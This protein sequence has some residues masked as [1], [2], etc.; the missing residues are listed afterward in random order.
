MTKQTRASKKRATAKKKADVIV[1]ETIAKVKASP[2]SWASERQEG[3]SDED[4]LLGVRCRELREEGEPWWAIARAM[5]LEGAGESAVTGK[6]GAARARLVYKKAFGSFPR[7][8]THGGK[9]IAERNEHIREMQKT[10][11]TERR[12]LAKSGK[13][14]ISPDMSDEDVATMLKGHRIRWWVQSEIVPDGMDQEACVHPRAPFYIMDEGEDRVVEF[15]EE[16]RNAPPD[17]RW[18]PAHIR[19][20]RLSSIYSVTR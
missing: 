17:V 20:V 11:K 16:H 19:T 4:W 3:V 18:I 6:K 8:F 1:A 9:T 14:V 2:D 13:S 7:T 5:D 15:R 10:K 12:M